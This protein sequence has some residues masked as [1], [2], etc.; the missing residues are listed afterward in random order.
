MGA[1]RL[2]A[3]TSWRYDVE[4]IAV[5]IIWLAIAFSAGFV[6]ATVLGIM[7]DK[8]GDERK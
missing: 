3:G 4:D 1:A 5:D 8:D 2:L 7:R 6:L